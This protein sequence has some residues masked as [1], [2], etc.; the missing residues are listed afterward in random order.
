MFIN[1]KHK[2]IFIHIPKNAG[3]SVK[4]FFGNKEF[5]HKHKTIKEIKDELL[6]IDKLTDDINSLLDHIKSKEEKI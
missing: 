4:T 5:H 6:N 3:T 1:H 2:F